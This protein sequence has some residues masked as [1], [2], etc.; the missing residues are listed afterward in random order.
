[1]IIDRYELSVLQ[2]LIIVEQRTNEPIHVMVNAMHQSLRILSS[3]DVQ[4]LLV[5]TERRVLVELMHVESFHHEQFNVTDLV[6]LVFLICIHCM[7]LLV[8]QLQIT[9]EKPNHER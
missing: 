6:V 1:M 7:K 5:T 3:V 9:V 4:M 2:L 8:N